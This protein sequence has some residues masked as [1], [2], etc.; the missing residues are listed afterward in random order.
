MHYPSQFNYPMLKQLIFNFKSDITSLDFPTELNNPF[1][2]DPPEIAKAAA[3]EFQ[4]FIA[5]EAPQW[6]YD[7][8]TRPGK[9]F[10]V[11]VVRQKDG[12]LGYLGTVSGKLPGNEDYDRFVPSIFD[13]SL[14]DYFLT[15]G[16]T[17][18]TAIGKQIITATSKEDVS[19][20]TKQRS[21]LSKSLQKRLFESYNFLNLSGEIK[22]VLSI[23]EEASAGKPSAA[24]GECAA[25]K[26][27]NSAI[28]HHLQPIA[29]A[30][31]W[32]GNSLNTDNRQHKDFYPACKS[33]CKPILEYMLENDSLY[34]S[35]KRSSQ[36]GKY[37]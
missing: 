37:I 26:L 18:V 15:K 14:D 11:L 19:A 33:K 8:R 22:N 31:F 24:T 35:V 1:G 13:E 17:E 6:K 5:L 4:D 25:P 23:F 32:W 20:L 36:L 27:L 9:I 34:T 30:E 16:L 12:K 10:G 21:Q 2:L 7:F 3:I 28:K 29:I